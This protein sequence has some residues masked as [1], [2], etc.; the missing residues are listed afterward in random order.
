MELSKEEVTRLRRLDPAGVHAALIASGAM[1][2]DDPLPKRVGDLRPSENSIDAVKF[3]RKCEYHEAIAW[4]HETFRD[5]QTHERNVGIRQVERELFESEV[6]INKLVKRQMDALGCSEARITLMFKEA[7]EAAQ[8]GADVEIVPESDLSSASSDT[9][10]S[11]AKRKGKFGYLIGKRTENGEK[12]EK[13]FNTRDIQNCVGMLRQRNGEGMNVLMTPMDRHCFYV[14]LD[15]ARN[16]RGDTESESPVQSWI[17]AGYKPCLALQTSW[18][19]RQI[20]FRIPKEPFRIIGKTGNDDSCFDRHGLHHYFQKINR[21]SGDHKISGLRHGIR[22]AGY[23]NMKPKHERVVEGKAWSLEYPFVK[24]EHAES[25]FCSK[26][27]RDALK[28]CREDV[29]GRA[30]LD[31]SRQEAARKHVAGLKNGEATQSQKLPPRYAPPLKPQT[32]LGRAAAEFD[33]RDRERP[34]QNREHSKC[35]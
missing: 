1:S 15:D 9:S 21:E 7:D 11:P 3:A 5:D 28:M 18:E 14:M 30:D 35:R 6:V 26:T 22:L 24:I 34:E 10:E 4:L 13:F 32:A 12:T 25:T 29:V 27:M 33:R 2:V 20:I 16:R 23:R 31:A 8:K 17:K 19:S